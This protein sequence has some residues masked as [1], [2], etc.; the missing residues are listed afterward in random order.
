MYYIVQELVEQ[1]KENEPIARQS[2][3]EK[4]IVSRKPVMQKQNKVRSTKKTSVLFHPQVA[5]RSVRARRG[6]TGQ[7]HFARQTLSSQSRRQPPKQ[8]VY[9]PPKHSPALL[10]SSTPF[11]GQSEGQKERYYR[12][13]QQSAKKPPLNGDLTSLPPNTDRVGEDTPR[14]GNSTS[15]PVLNLPTDVSTGGSS[16]LTNRPRMSTSAPSVV[17]DDKRAAKIALSSPVDG[18][19]VPGDGVSSPVVDEQRLWMESISAT[20]AHH[21]QQLETFKKNTQ[22]QLGHLE[23]NLSSQRKARKKNAEN[24]PSPDDEIEESVENEGVSYDGMKLDGLMERLRELEGE[25][26]MIRERWRT[27]TYEDPPLAKPPIVHCSGEQPSN[28]GSKKYCKE[29]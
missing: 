27:I 19:S 2:V 16:S 29:F 7:P 10:H 5:P 15:Y 8:T 9:S 25:E 1:G 18:H 28:I 20:L 14:Q 24:A 26:D 12:S 4:N 13:V 6:R 3:Q 22:K 23:Q 17:T 21:S 11:T